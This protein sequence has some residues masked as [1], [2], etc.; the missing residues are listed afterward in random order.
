MNGIYTCLW[1][2]I[3]GFNPATPQLHSLSFPLPL[4]LSPS[5]AKLV[6]WVALKYITTAV[7]AWRR[8]LSK[9]HIYGI[10]TADRQD[11]TILALSRE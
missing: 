7:R 3:N 8:L 6:Q 11:I 5:L 2:A 10:V 1:P 9:S 4:S